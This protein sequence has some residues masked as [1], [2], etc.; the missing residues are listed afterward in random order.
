VQIISRK[1]LRDFYEKPRYSDSKGYIEAW[2]HEAKKAKWKNPNEI[3]ERYAN[4]SILKNNRVVFNICSNKY[5]LIV[6]I[7][8]AAQIAYIRFIGTHEEYN[9]IDAEKI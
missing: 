4:A 6:K 8:Y 1:T 2:Y 3:K 7:N 5:R 9:G